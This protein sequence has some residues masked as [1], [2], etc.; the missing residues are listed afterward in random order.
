[1]ASSSAEVF[2]SHREVMDALH[3]NFASNDDTQKVIFVDKLQQDIADDCRQKE[4]S[5]KTTIT[6]RQ[7]RLCILASAVL[8]VFSA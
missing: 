7:H 1:M 6:G 4:N 2:A 5:I 8:N 3:Q